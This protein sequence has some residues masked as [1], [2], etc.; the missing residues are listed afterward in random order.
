MTP[1]ERF[2]MGA[3]YMTVITACLFGLIFAAA[4]AGLSTLVVPLMWLTA[5]SF[6]ATVVAF[7]HDATKGLW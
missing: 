6:G 2:A 1:S 3:F 4:I 7:V 5:L